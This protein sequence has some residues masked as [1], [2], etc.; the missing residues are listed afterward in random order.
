MESVDNNKF[1][2]KSYKR[3]IEAGP[4]VYLNP[5]LDLLANED[6]MCNTAME[7]APNKKRKRTKSDIAAFE[8]TALD[9]GTGTLLNSYY[10]PNYFCTTTACGSWSLLRFLH[11]D[12]DFK[13][14]AF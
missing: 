13:T 1:E 14:T 10:L 4:N 12:F 2:V 3:K 7:I 11:F 8:N 6:P 5:A 9:L